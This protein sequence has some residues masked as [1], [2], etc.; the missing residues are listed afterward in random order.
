MNSYT[1]AALERAMKVEELM[2]QAMSKKVSWWQAAEIL[3]A[4]ATGI[5]GAGGAL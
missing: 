4:S 1:H 3:G 5:C 2:L